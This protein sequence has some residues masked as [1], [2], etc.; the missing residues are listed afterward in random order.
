MVPGGAGKSVPGVPA[1]AEK[2]VPG[3]PEWAG[4]FMVYRCTVRLGHHTISTLTADPNIPSP[5]Y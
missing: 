3:V 4:M 5:H 2:S 1:G